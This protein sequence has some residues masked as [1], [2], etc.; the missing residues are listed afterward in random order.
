M[1]VLQKLFGAVTTYDAE[2][3]TLNVD[4]AKKQLLEDGDSFYGR[5]D[6]YWLS[7]IIYAEANGQPFDGMVG[8]GNVVLNRVASARFPG[9]VEGVVF[10]PGQFTPVDNG[11]IYNE[12]SEQAVLAAKMCL[13]GVNTVGESLYFVNPAIGA[14]GWF[15]QN[16]TL[17]IVI[18]DHA[19]YA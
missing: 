12:P 10:E 13:E 2:N 15:N 6:L 14:T 1:D 4:T 16:L 11:S 8:V 3:A 17:T 7:R 9:S 19:F 5:Q 18:A